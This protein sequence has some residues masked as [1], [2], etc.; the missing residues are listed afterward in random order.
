LYIGGSIVLGAEGDR[1]GEIWV[2]DS[3]FHCCR[4]GGGVDCYGSQSRKY[5]II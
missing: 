4:I 1:A 5:G 2:F 3:E